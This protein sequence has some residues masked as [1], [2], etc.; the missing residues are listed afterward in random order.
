MSSLFAAQ[1]PAEVGT[2]AAS[3]LRSVRS[4]RLTAPLSALDASDK[5]PGGRPARAR[6]GVRIDVPG[7]ETIGFGLAM[8]HSPRWH[9]GRPWVGDAGSGTIG[10]GDA[11]RGRSEPG[12][13]RHGGTLGLDFA[14]RDTVVD[15]SEVRETAVFSGIPPT[16]RLSEIDRAG[17]VRVIDTATGQAVAL[18]KFADGAQEVFA[19]LLT[20]GR[21]DPDLRTDDAERINLSFV[22]PD[23][24]L[25]QVPESF[26]DHGTGHQ[27]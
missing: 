4:T 8:L 21:R 25:A 13:E 19:G 22:L 3:P 15:L 9:D 11:A 27:S 18:R 16:G 23:D 1:Q 7:G 5:A 20:P 14:G 24:A 10:G 2:G 12:A 26:Q 6:G 17:D